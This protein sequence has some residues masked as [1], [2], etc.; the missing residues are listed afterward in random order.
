MG[1]F[2]T[3][4]AFVSPGD[5]EDA[6][7]RVGQRTGYKHLSSKPEATLRT[8]AYRQRR[9]YRLFGGL[10]AC[11]ILQMKVRTKKAQNVRTRGVF[12]HPACS[13]E[14]LWSWPAGA[15]P[16]APHEVV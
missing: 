14:Q 9:G 15:P 4:G 3:D 11:E 7:Q 1:I 2:V 13:Q 12:A 6:N 10:R 16:T 5:M 8:F